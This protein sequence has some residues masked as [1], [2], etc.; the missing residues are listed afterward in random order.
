[1]HRSGTSAISG[2]LAKLGA[3]PPKTL[4]SGGADNPRGHWESDVITAMHDE[5][6]ASA[7]SRWDDW[8]PFNPDWYVTPA[9]TQFKERAKALLAS[10][11][12]EAPAFVLKDPRIC[13]FARFWFEIFAEEGI[14][15][16]LVLPVRLPLEVARSLK[17]R[18]GSPL[19]YG[20][21]LWLRHALD[22]ELVTR[23]MPRVIL[24]WNSFLKDWRVETARIAQELGI[25]WPKQ[26]DFT[27][28]DIDSFLT[29][30][31]KHENVSADDAR[32][33]PDMHEW[34]SA[35]CDALLELA[36]EPVSNSARVRLDEVRA[37]FDDASHLFGRALGDLELQVENISQA[38]ATERQLREHENQQHTQLL[39]VERKLEA[40]LEAERARSA[41]LKQ[42]AD[43]RLAHMEQISAKLEHKLELLTAD[44]NTSN[45]KLAEETQARVTAEHNM[46]L[47]Q[48]SLSALKEEYDTALGEIKNGR[49]ELARTEVQV[50][51]LSGKLNRL[52]THPFTS[53]IRWVSGQGV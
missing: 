43:E 50:E 51:L 44:L 47:A 28:A 10:E 42:L 11:F 48:S 40:T 22:A 24:P 14:T 23:G 30:E 27:A 12:G 46:E 15:P 1:M 19:S 29:A 53:F 4:M 52:R 18:G 26:S 37:K 45:T 5:L 39:E 21:L 16:R 8:R 3:T 20:L 36:R 35:A 41:E 32:V 49:D 25:H 7:G 31:L 6:L 17:T 33:H 38:L 2:T 9:A 34:V 13:R